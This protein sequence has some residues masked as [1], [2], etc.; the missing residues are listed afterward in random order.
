MKWLQINITSLSTS[1]KELIEYEKRNEYEAIFIQETDHKDEKC[2][3]QNFKTKMYTKYTDKTQGYGVATFIKENQKNIFHDN[4]ED[5]KLECIWN[6]M[7]INKK[8]VLIGNIYVPPGDSEQLDYLDQFLEQNQNGNI[9]ILGDFNSRSTMW[10][11]RVKKSTKMGKKLEDI[12][13]R[14]NLTVQTNLD[15]TYEH[16]QG[17]STI[18]LTLTRGIEIETTVVHLDLIKTCHRGLI[19]MIK[20]GEEKDQTQEHQVRYNTKMQIGKNGKGN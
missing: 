20:E 15:Y 9:V 10:D 14:H 17:K 5:N 18:D 6:T 12:I 13:N 4:S 2:T 7:Y 8:L 3:F 1:T 19:I 11:K 16:P